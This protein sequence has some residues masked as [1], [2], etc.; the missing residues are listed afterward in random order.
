MSKRISP[1]V[2]E[3]VVRKG[4]AETKGGRNDGGQKNEMELL[5]KSST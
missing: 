3:K 2:S 5:E 1:I 4:R